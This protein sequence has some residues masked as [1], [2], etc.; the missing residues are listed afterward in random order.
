MAR[1]KKPKIDKTMAV[2][3]APRECPDDWDDR[4]RY[5]WDM[6]ADLLINVG[7]LTV[8]TLHDFKHLVNDIIRLDDQQE[9]IKNENAS[10]MQ[11][12]TRMLSS[13]EEEKT[14]K[15]S[16]ASKLERDL[17]ILVT[18]KK[19]DWMLTPD[20]AVNVF[21]PKKEKSTMGKLIDK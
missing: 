20:T 21:K 8:V 5:Y 9:F 13:G 7:L 17:S 11:V 3:L 18:K 4:M 16:A 10:S 1:L 15:E 6:W 12:N 2:D 14:I 19:K